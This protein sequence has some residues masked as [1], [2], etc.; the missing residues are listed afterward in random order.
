LSTQ[1][2]LE[3]DVAWLST[4]V[5]TAPETRRVPNTD[6]DTRRAGRLFIYPP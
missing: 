2:L 5:I 1:M 3:V 4:A 6:S